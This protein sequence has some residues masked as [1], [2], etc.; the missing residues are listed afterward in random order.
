MLSAPPRPA[1][2]EGVE[3]RKDVRWREQRRRVEGGEEWRG[4]ERA[5]ERGN[6]GEGEENL[7][8]TQK[9]NEIGRGGR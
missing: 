9:E 1:E 8:R 2:S 3:E 7:M 5:A 6:V 4:R